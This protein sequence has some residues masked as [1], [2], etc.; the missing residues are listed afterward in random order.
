NRLLAEHWG[1]APDSVAQA[2]ESRPPLEALEH[3]P[4]APVH[5]TARRRR[6]RRLTP[7]LRA[8][9]APAKRDV[10]PMEREPSNGIGRVMQLGDP[11]SA[12][13]AE[14][15]IAMGTDEGRTP[16]L[17]TM[18]W[19]AGAI[20]LLAVLLVVLERMVFGLLDL[21]AALIT[22]IETLGMSSW[23]IP[24]ILAAF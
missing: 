4:K 23:R 8:A 10:T 22:G 14:A 15:L 13:S 16:A 12:I 6:L 17:R 9:R 1:S 5:S 18:A 11:E 2:L 7:W 3:L 20:A 24:L 21:G 19:T